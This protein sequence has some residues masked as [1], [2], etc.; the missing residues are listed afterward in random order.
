MAE[1][2]VNYVDSPFLLSGSLYD[3]W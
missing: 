3:S 2:L 1:K